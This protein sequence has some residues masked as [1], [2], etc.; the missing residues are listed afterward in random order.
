MI[1][2]RWTRVALMALLA[3]ALTALLGCGAD[4][5]EFTQTLTFT[6]PLNLSTAVRD[7][8]LT[9]G[10][11]ATEDMNLVLGKGAAFDLAAD[12][13]E[14]QDRAD[15]NKFVDLRLQSFEFTVTENTLTGD[16]TGVELAIA[17]EGN[18]DPNSPEA[19]L[20][21]VIE[22]IKAGETPS[23]LGTLQP[24]NSIALSQHIFKLKFNMAQGVTV[25]IKAGE[26]IP[27]GRITIESK[28]IF[29]MT[30]EDS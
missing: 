25:P 29:V 5:T 6:A 3:L 22:E 19:V 4:E 26:T 1:D 23:G 18:E 9:P 24:E 2:A 16:L 17:P 30:S 11:I 10:E 7:A 21:G 13:P 14:L 8:G 15:N 20:F 12:S 27:G 28:V